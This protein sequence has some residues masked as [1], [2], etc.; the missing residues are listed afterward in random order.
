[1]QLV[2][3]TALALK[4]GHRKSIDIDLFSTSDFNSTEISNHLSYAYDVSR[5]QTITNGVFCSIIP[6]GH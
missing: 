5:I 1:M 6:L 2:G 4:I 3:G